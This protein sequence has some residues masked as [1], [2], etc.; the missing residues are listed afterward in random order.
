MSKYSARFKKDVVD[1]Y[2][3]GGAGYESIAREAGISSGRLRQWVANYGAHGMRGLEKKYGTY[4]ADF[5]L[6]VLTRMF[7]EGMT[8]QA[9]CAMFNIR[10]PGCIKD[11]SLAYDRGGLEAL[12]P[13]PRGRPPTM[14]LKPP[15][16]R[17]PG[18]APTVKQLL[19]ENE[20]L[21][22]EVAYLKKLD[23]LIQAKQ[24]AAQKK[25]K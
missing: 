24:L 21:R 22:A 6:K 13:K 12:I 10:N 16:S 5:K 20:Y 7:N 8:A 15:T 1:Q 3:L 2:L 19:K 18:E 14:K 9:V 23:A 4:S 17:E 11:W 25:R